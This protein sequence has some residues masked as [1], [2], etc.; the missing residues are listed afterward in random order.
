MKLSKLLDFD[1]IVIQCHNNPDADALASGMA[2]LYYF[3][4]HNKNCHFIYGGKFKV[5]KSNLKLMVEDL[6]IQAT[7]VK[8]QQD[9]SALLGIGEDELPDLLV[10]VDCQLGEGNVASFS[11]K[12]V[13]TIDHHQITGKLPK[14]S[15]VR[16]VQASCSTVVWDLLRKEGI[17]VND[18][19]KL[20]TALYY[21]LMTDS[22]NFTELHHPLDRD[23]RDELHYMKSEIIRFRNANIS[24]DELRIAG[25]ALLNYSYYELNKNA[26]V[27]TDPCDP[28]I[29][30]LISDM[31]L[32]VDSVDTCLAYSILD[33]GVKISVR[34]CIKEVKANELADYICEGVGDGGGHIVKAG[35]FIQ[36]ELFEKEFG[37]Y[38]S[39]KIAEFC[40]NRI[41]EYFENTDIIYANE[42]QADL[43]D[44]SLY[45]KKSFKLGYVKGTNIIEEGNIATIRTL[46]GD[47]DVLIKN[48]TYI[49][50]GVKGEIYP[51]SKDRFDVGYTATDDDYVF[52]GE[53][54]PTVRNY[55]EGNTIDI[56]PFAQSCVSTG[57]GRIYAKKVTKR[58]K[59]FTEWDPE[60][61]YLGKPGDYLALIEDKPNDVY[62]IEN[63]IFKKTYAPV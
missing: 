52:P 44:M 4:S 16:P 54:A 18:D 42:Y 10:T 24:Q 12:K 57:G 36:R 19:E 21:G 38:S 50:I 7:R 37:T 25:N 47:V 29:L 41:A 58:T 59:V 11:A 8:T 30:G 53:Y 1:N 32:E 3:K 56:L 27:R 43:S 48:D 55:L 39:K 26:I 61:Y 62:I 33:F 34:S 6:N 60:K 46:E 51:I 45:T 17:N 5:R 22:G 28:N 2:L 63:G 13:A 23:M 20:A 14:L 31:L 35:G 40:A 9:I 15:D 49:M